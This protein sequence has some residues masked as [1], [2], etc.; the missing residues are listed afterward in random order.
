LLINIKFALLG[1]FASI[2]LSVCESRLISVPGQ[3]NDLKVLIRKRAFT[4]DVIFK[5][6]ALCEFSANEVR[7]RLAR[8]N[9]F[10]GK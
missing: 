10:K 6:A 3:A 4:L 9:K 8:S 2:E 1:W 7:L 5:P